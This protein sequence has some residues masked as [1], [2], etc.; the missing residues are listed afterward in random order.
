M[1]E[2]PEFKF[3]PINLFNIYPSQYMLQVINQPGN[4]N[5]N[6]QAKPQQKMPP[7]RGLDVL[8]LWKA[9]SS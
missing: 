2:W 7:R 1:I 9:R 5:A 8:E 6:I 4:K 3:P